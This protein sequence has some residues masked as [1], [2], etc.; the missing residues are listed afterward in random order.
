M[1]PKKSWCIAIIILIVF[2]AEL[3]TLDLIIGIPKANSEPMHL[4][5]TL[6]LV[7]FILGFALFVTVVLAVYPNGSLSYVD[8][9]A[10]LFPKM[11]IVFTIILI[12]FFA[13]IRHYYTTVKL[14]LDL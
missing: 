4:F 6:A 2:V 13:G 3:Y 12:I 5:D 7:L 8:R 1:F 10:G 9:I 14:G 11:T